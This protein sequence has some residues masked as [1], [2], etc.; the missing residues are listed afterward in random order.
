MRSWCGV[1]WTDPSGT[2]ATAACGE[3]GRIDTGHFTAA[4]FHAPV[5]NFSASRDSFIAW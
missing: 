2:H 1:L 3:R 4:N 5:Y